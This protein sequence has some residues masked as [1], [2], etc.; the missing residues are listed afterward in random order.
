MMNLDWEELRT[1]LAVAKS[2]S[3]SRAAKDIG[4]TQPTVSRRIE[5]LEGSLKAKLF[6]RNADGV[7]PTDVGAQ[8]LSYAESMAHNAE[9]IGRLANETDNRP[10][11]RVGIAAPDGIAAFWLIPNLQR[12]MRAY[13]K[14]FLS[15]DCGIWKSTS[16]DLPAD[17]SLQVHE[18][19]NPDAIRIPICHLHYSMF[20]TQEYL[21]LYGTPNDLNEIVNHRHVVHTA[22]IMQKHLWAEKADAAQQML[23]NE[24]QTNS[25]AVSLMSVLCGLGIGALPTAAADLYPQ[26]VPLPVGRVAT[27]RLWLV[28]H[29]EH[30]QSRKVEVVKDWIESIFDRSKMVWVREEFIDPYDFKERQIG[31]VP[32]LP[33]PA[34]QT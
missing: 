20:A 4:V 11:G 6:N 29:K 34:A 9:S 15:F 26:L 21:D 22:Q 33:E 1:F 24:I 13:P 3:F 14:L 10:E 18:P 7:V 12:F 28:Y 5:L 25:S 31:D 19:T 27:V 8:I 23:R 16:E 17:M 30:K 32:G 2:G